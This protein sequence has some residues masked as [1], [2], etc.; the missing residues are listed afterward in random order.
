MDNKE[1][2]SVPTATGPPNVEDPLAE[3]VRELVLV[4]PILNPVD[5]ETGR[6]LLDAFAV[7]DDEDEG[8]EDCGE[9]VGVLEGDEDGSLDGEDVPPPVVAPPPVSPVD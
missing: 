7:V 9:E 2:P 5:S 1:V 6:V 4:G 3:G 8:A